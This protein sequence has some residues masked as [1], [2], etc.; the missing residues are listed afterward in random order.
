VQTVVTPIA[1]CIRYFNYPGKSGDGSVD[2]VT[3]GHQLT[4]EQRQAV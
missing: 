2:D 1:K 3:I 4:A